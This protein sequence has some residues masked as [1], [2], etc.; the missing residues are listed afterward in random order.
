LAVKKKQD[1]LT[2]ICQLLKHMAKNKDF[3]VALFL[4]GFCLTLIFYLIP[5]YVRIPNITGSI[6]NPRFFPYSITFVLAFLSI[7]LLYNSHKPAKDI[8]RPKYKRMDW[9]TIVCITLLFA[10]YFGIRVI[11]M[12]PASFLAMLVMMR[13]FGFKKWGQALIFTIVLVIL[14]FIFFERIAQVSIPRGILFE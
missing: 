5:S 14:I 7:L 8:G 10:Y 11:G 1:R 4:I 3:Y 6:F 2:I 12:A 9:I 13:L